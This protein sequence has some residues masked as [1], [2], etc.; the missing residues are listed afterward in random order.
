MIP[1][2]ANKESTDQ[3]ISNTSESSLTISTK[4]LSKRFNREWIFKN[5]TYDFKSGNT[6]A[7]TGANGS[8][9]S[10]LIQVLSGAMPP[11]D[12]SINYQSNSGDT[13][14]AEEIYKKIAIAAPYMDL[15]DEFT[16]AEQ[17]KFHFSL[18]KPRY[19]TTVNDL[20]S[21]MYLE[22]AG[23]KHIAN[24]SSGMRQR[25]KLGLAFYTE[26]DLVLLDEPGTNLDSKAFEWYLTQFQKLPKSCLTVIA[27]NNPL[28]YREN[29]IILN[30]ED[31]KKAVAAKI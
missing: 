2:S 1:K 28:E 21:I 31:Y 13:I 25:V 23:D 7:V 6:Y 4:D 20:L 22:K 19:N 16:L 10:T 3:Q 27:S 11:T 17:I 26:A 18:R 12:G 15:I 24:F 29:T 5:L 9:K 30:I 8:G 14:A